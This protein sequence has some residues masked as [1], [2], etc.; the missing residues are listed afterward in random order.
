MA[1]ISVE[2]DF[3]SGRA[4]M[5]RICEKMKVILGVLNVVLAVVLCA[6]LPGVVRADWIKGYFSPAAKID[7]INRFLVISDTRDSTFFGYGIVRAGDIN[8]D[9]IQDVIICRTKNGQPD[10]DDSAFLFLGGRLPGQIPTQAYSNLGF[11]MG[12]VGDVNRDGYDD[13]GLVNLPF[14]NY[15]L[16]YGGVGPFDT[17]CQILRGFNTHITRA[18]DLDGDG[19]L[20]IVVSK[21]LGGGYVYI[22]SVEPILDTIPKYIIPDTALSFGASLA[23][24]DFNGDGWADLAVSATWNRDTDFVKF[25][26]GGAQFDTIADWVI[27]PT[28][29][30]HSNFGEK[31]VPVG[32][33]NSDGIEDIY[34]GG[35]WPVADGIHF[36]GTQIHS[37]PDVTINSDLVGGYNTLTYVASAGDVNHD[38]YPDIVASF[39]LPD[40]AIYVHLGGPAADSIPDVVIT[41]A[42]IPDFQI[43]FGRFCVTGVGDFNGDGIDD[44]AVY[45]KNGY[46]RSEVNFFAGWNSVVADVP[47]DGVTLPIR[48]SLFQNYPNPFNPTT[49][50]EFDLAKPARTVVRI[51]NTLGQQVRT[52][53]DRPLGVGVHRIQWD[54]CGDRGNAM[55]TGVYVYRLVA[56][57]FTEARKMVLVK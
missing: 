49:S 26:W 23:V 25:Y 46:L 55:P 45:S 31:L 8:K 24:G 35:T 43:A 50:I 22:F 47:G 39:P 19:K 7:S 38:G 20:E 52:L 54:G 4:R 30:P 53:V 21:D 14:T 3:G 40:D 18:A 56:G 6:T 42:M 2:I 28:A 51:Y 57:D 34:I 44:I 36:G 13:F 12:N 32:D 11:W 29:Q 5:M 9:G 48:F 27:R 41:D 1:D 15:K 37:K 33:F 17:T 16:F 10:G